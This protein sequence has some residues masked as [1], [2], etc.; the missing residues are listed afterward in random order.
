MQNLRFYSYFYSKAK[1]YANFA[2][3][4]SGVELVSPFS[5]PCQGSDHSYD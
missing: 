3:V 5:L 1:N 4:K 2:K